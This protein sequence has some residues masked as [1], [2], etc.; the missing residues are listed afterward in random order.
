MRLENLHKLWLVD[1]K[2]TFNNCKIIY[3]TLTN[4]LLLFTEKS[5]WRWVIEETG[6]QYLM[7]ILKQ[8]QNEKQKE[9]VWETGWAWPED[10]DEKSS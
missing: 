10:S 2:K 1:T 5:N 7:R 4:M 3:H 6:R 9:W 8:K